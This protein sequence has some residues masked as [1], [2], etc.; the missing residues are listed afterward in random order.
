M[1]DVTLTSVTRAEWI[2]FRTVRSTIMGYVVT[3]ALT[4]GLGALITAAIRAHWQTM[5]PLSKLAF[6]PVSTSLGGTL[7]AQFAVGVIGI[8]FIT[9]EYA[10]GSIRTTLAATP[11]RVQVVA[12]KLLVLVSVTVVVA[13]VV[14]FATFLMGQR[15]FSGVVPTASLSSGPVLRS[16]ALGGIYLTLLA[17]LGF[18]LGLILRQQS[19]AI[20]VFTSLLLIVPIV[21]FVLPQS[22]QTSI[23]RYEPS[24]LGR[25]MM[26]VTPPLD[27]FGAWTATLLLIVY[28]AI[29]LAIGVALLQRRDA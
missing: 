29:V 8:L 4:L 12:A 24:A 14:V 7:F 17:V 20:S 25:A 26:S 15:I 9:S 2:K 1:S 22:W 13:E 3:F 28:V 19:A 27:M 11:R 16:V 23:S 10:S 6:D 5:D 18:G 21:I